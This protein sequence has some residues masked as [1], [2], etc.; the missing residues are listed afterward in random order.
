MKKITQITLAMTLAAIPTG[1]RAQGENMGSI[2]TV[3][4]AATEYS[5]APSLIAKDEFGVPLSPPE[6]TDNNYYTVESATKIVTTE[7]WG[8]KLVTTKFSNKEFL[9]FLFEMGEIDSITGWALVEV[10]TQESEGPM[11]YIKKLNEVIDVS[12]YLS[13]MADDMPSTWSYKNVYTEIIAT[14]L[15][16]TVETGSQSGKGMLTVNLLD[17][18][19]QGMVAW[20][21]TLKTYGTGDNRYTMWLSGAINVTGLSGAATDESDSPTAITG[22]VTIA[23][24]KPI[25]LSTIGLG[26]VAAR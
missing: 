16:T 9:M 14:G 15:T 6:Y 4:L 11:F 1:A 2:A 25:D 13:V 23:A 8:T 21:G 7:E 20:T 12:P 22:T 24:A 5:D 10:E 26:I 17:M 19:L 18:P 3:T